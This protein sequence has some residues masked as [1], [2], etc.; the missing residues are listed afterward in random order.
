MKIRTIGSGRTKNVIEDTKIFNAVRVLVQFL[1]DGGIVGRAFY[2]PKKARFFIHEG[3]K[4][5]WFRRCQLPSHKRSFP[6]GHEQGNSKEIG[7]LSVAIIGARLILFRMRKESL[8]D[9]VSG[10]DYSL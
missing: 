8:N 4:I 1:E 7:E 5:V 10:A 9:I 2:Q 6:G 3:V